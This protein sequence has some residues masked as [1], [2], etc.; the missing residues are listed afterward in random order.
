MLCQMVPVMV[1]RHLQSA[2][3]VVQGPSSEEWAFI[4]SMF[5]ELYIHQDRKLS[6]V[7]TLLAAEFGFIAT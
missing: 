5:I 4:K 2:T 6:D 3:N 1:P 7:S